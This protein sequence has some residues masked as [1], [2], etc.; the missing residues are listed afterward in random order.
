MFVLIEGGSYFLY[1]MLNNRQLPRR[2][3]TL[4]LVWIFAFVI[5]RRRQE[6]LFSDV[7]KLNSFF[8]SWILGVVYLKN[9]AV[10]LWSFAR[11]NKGKKEVKAE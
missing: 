4:N 6:L 2:M 7:V 8:L 5:W 1:Q 10:L 9:K 11:R 3:A